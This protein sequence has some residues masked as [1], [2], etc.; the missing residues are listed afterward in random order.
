MEH[1]QVN[2]NNFNKAEIIKKITPIVEKATLDYELQLLEIDLVNE[3]NK[4]HLRIFIYNP[5]SP[6]THEECEKVTIQLAEHLDLII[7]VP[8]YLEVSSPGTERKL[9][10]SKE[11]IIFKGSRVKIK[12]KKAINGVFK[13]Y[14]GIITDYN[15]ETGLKIKSEDINQIIQI[16]EKNISQI[17]LEPKY[18]F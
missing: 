9:K 7:P 2:K 15:E 12:L 16:D 18:E 5:K 6:I 8:Y 14:I 13:T 1:F 3:F 4:W 17:K 10:S 11:Y